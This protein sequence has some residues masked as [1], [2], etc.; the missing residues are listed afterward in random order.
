M[1]ERDAHIRALRRLFSNN[2]VVVLLGPRGAGKSTLAREFAQRSRSNSYFFDL[3]AAADRS[4]LEDPTLALSNLQGLVVLDEI[5]RAPQVLSDVRQLSLRSWNPARFLI[6]S[7]IA[8]EE[9]I[10]QL[11]PLSDFTAHYELPGFSSTELPVSQADLL[12]LRGGLPRSYSADSDEESYDWRDRYVRDFLERDI[13]RLA[14]N[15]PTDRIERF[16]IML[17]H[18]H[19]QVW[20]GS[21]LARSL[22]VSHHTARRYLKIIESAFI[23]RR[24]E[25]WHANLPWRQVK[26]PRVYFRDSGLLHYCLGISNL[27]ELERHPRSGASWEGFVLENLMR[28]L[29]KQETQ[30]YFWAA[31]TGARVDLIAKSGRQ[32]R[33]FE[34]RRTTSPRITR[35]VK[36]ALE[37]L[38]LTRMDIVYAGSERLRLD[39]RVRAI[40]AERLHEDL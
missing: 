29:G 36:T 13:H 6:L 35:T 8:T 9:L 38:S 21:E 33:G 14:S 27:R 12:W 40:S 1:I 23:V 19:A 15:A 7:S 26:S 16:L 28:V 3:R 17:A 30:F 2:A 20:N 39:R 24:L 37:E 34:I 25:P 5:H 32:L 31:H 4:R 11:Q 22:G 18:C 10:E